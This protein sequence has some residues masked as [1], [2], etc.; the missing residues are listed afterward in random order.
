M[1]EQGVDQQ[2]RLGAIAFGLGTLIYTGLEFV[3]FFEVI[4]KTYMSMN[5]L[6][7]HGLQLLAH[8]LWHQPGPPHDLH[9]H[10]D[11]L[12]LHALQA[13]HQQEQDHCQVWA[14]ALAGKNYVC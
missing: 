1:K 3:H 9:L 8:P 12:S 5:V 4:S 13:Q 2:I 10:A 14:D 6:G 7:A 11:V